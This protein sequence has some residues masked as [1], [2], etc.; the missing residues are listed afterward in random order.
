MGLT[1]NGTD[2]PGLIGPLLQRL[3]L[4]LS[5]ISPL[6]AHAA[7]VSEAGDR[8]GLVSRGDLG[9]IAARHTADS[10]LFALARRPEPGERWVDVG[11]GAG[12]P[13]I[14]LACC[15]PA[16]RFTLLEPQAKRAGF[17]EL[18]AV[19]LGLANVDVSPH[20]LEDRPLSCDVAVARA[21]RDPGEALPALLG[22]LRPGGVAIVAAGPDVPTPPGAMAVR[23]APTVAVDSPGLLFMMTKEL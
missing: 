9:S 2:D 3:G 23:F 17:L 14:V 11:A 5:L 12:F 6:L 10:L 13:G 18:V 20:R 22:A 15:Y 7:A 16:A 19:G 21:F 8:L 4:P 1:G